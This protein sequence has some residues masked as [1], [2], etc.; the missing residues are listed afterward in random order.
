MC[1]VALCGVVWR[2][3]V[4]CCCVLWSYW[5]VV[6]C[7]VFSCLCFCG[8]CG[9]GR[10]VSC[11]LCAFLWFLCPFWCRVV[12]CGVV[13]CSFCVLWCAFLWCC[14]FLVVWVVWCGWTPSLRRTCSRFLL[15]VFAVLAY[16]PGFLFAAPRQTSCSKVSTGEGCGFLFSVCVFV[17][18]RFSCRVVRVVWLNPVLASYLLSVF[19]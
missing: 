13:W 19:A 15:E 10:V 5:V 18:L 14:V 6:W 3:V 16:P 2:Y 11:G 4:W 8:S 12:L 1:R 7:C 17:V 9:V